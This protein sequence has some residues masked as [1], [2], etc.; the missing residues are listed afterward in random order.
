MKRTRMSENGDVGVDFCQERLDAALWPSQQTLSETNDAEGIVRLAKRLAKA[1]SKIVVMES[2]GRLHIP[3]ALELDKRGVPYR[4]VNPGQVRDFARAMGKLAKTDR[5]D[6][7]MRRL[8]FF[9]TPLFAFENQEALHALG[10]HGHLSVRFL[11]SL[12]D[13]V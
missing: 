13:L 11:L 12:H 9:S 3:L 7:L 8:D 5:I 4:I 1:K 2:T 6:G 10:H